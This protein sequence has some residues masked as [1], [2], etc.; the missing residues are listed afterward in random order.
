MRTHMNA[1]SQPIADLVQ[2]W[3]SN[4]RMFQAMNSIKNA[5]PRHWFGI[6]CSKRDLFSRLV[7]D[8]PTLPCRPRNVLF[9]NLRSCVQHQVHVGKLSWTYGKLD[10]GVSMY[11]SS[12]TKYTLNQFKR[13]ADPSEAAWLQYGMSKQDKTITVING[14]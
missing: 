6:V 10:F 9:E 14:Q 13:S 5:N 2:I 7:D 8:M 3:N 1:I 4:F 11:W 12:R